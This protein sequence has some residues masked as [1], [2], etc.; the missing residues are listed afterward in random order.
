M[1]IMKYDTIF[2][3]PS[4]WGGGDLFYTIAAM[5]HNTRFEQGYI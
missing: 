3:W 5:T 1:F 2:F 4:G